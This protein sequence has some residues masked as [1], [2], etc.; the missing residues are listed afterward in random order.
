MAVIT[1]TREEKDES[2][3]QL[4]TKVFVEQPWLHW[5]GDSFLSY[6]QGKEKVFRETC[7]NSVFMFSSKTIHHVCLTK[8]G[9]YL[10]IQSV[11]QKETPNRGS[12]LE[13]EKNFL[14]QTEPL[15]EPNRVFVFV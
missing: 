14:H 8:H 2:L 11:L 10:A 3:T 7:K 9:L 15:F 12:L 5:W 4:I 1:W 6:F 13:E